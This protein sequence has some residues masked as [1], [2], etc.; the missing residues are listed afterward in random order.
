MDVC[1]EKSNVIKR[2]NIKGVK[3]APNKYLQTCY[4]FLDT[5]KYLEDKEIDQ[6]IDEL[7]KEGAEVVV[8]SEA[9]SVDDPS[10][11]RFVMDRSDIPATAGHELT[12]VYGLEIRTLTAAINASILPKAISTAEFVESAVRK[13]KG[14]N[15]PLMV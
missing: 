11:E 4:R 13:K 2:T 7:K 6:A 15:A 1:L 10:N 12:G 14:I 5:S 8:V 9:Y 3:L